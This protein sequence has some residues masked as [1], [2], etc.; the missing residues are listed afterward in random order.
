MFLKYCSLVYYR[1]QTIMLALTLNNKTVIYA[2]F[3]ANNFRI[4]QLRPNLSGG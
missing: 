2:V 4:N 1:V 3:L